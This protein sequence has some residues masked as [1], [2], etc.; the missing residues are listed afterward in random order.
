M[1]ATAFQRRRREI[2]A[3]E[4][5]VEETVI[6]PPAPFSQEEYEKRVRDKAK[7]L[8]IKSWHVKSVETLEKEIAEKE[9]A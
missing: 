5:K 8:G 7:S 1:G 3:L 2:A 6:Q 9:G 4:A